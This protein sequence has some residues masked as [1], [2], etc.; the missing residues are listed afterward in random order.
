MAKRSSHI[1]DLNRAVE[2][3]MK[4]HETPPPQVNPR[5]AALLKIASDLRDLPRESFKVQLRDQLMAEAHPESTQVGGKALVTHDDIMQRLAELEHEPKFVPY[6]VRAALKGLPESTM[7]FIVPMNEWTLIASAGREYSHW[8]KHGGDEMLYIVDG[9]ADVKIAIDDGFVTKRLRKGSLFICPEGLWH[10]VMPREYVQGLYATP[11]DTVAS[12]A[13]N[14]PRS[15]R[16]KSAGK[17]HFKVHDMNAILR[18]LEMLRITRDT[19]KEEADASVYQLGDMG[20]RSLGVMRF[21]GP[22]P[23]ERHMGG[24]ELLFTLEGSLYVTTM[25]DDGPV[26]RRL[27]EGSIFIC[28]QGLWHRQVAEPSAAILYGTPTRTT[29][30]TFAEDPRTEN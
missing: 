25:T 4:G 17:P 22:T 6:D 9:E 27:D 2:G 21:A 8:E 23:W 1:E 29:Q 10:K 5:I 12:D 15:T 16:P 20:E 30:H 18:N 13:K 19:T 3:L 14:P 11:T 26:E 28:P 7:R 24:D